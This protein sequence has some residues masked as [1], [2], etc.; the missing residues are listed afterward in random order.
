MADKLNVVINLTA[1]AS[2]VWRSAATGDEAAQKIM[3]LSRKRAF[4]VSRIVQRALR[5]ALPTT[6]VTISEHVQIG[7]PAV[8][9][10]AESKGSSDPVAFE[11]DGDNPL[12]RSVFLSLHIQTLSSVSKPIRVKAMREGKTLH[13]SVQLIGFEAIA[14]GVGGGFIVIKLN[15]G[16]TGKSANY[17]AFLKGHG[18]DSTL[19]KDKWDNALDK[20]KLGKPGKPFFYQTDRAVGF[21]DYVDR[22]V[23]VTQMKAGVGLPL[24]RIPLVNKIPGVDKLGVKV[25]DTVLTFEG[26]GEKAEKLLIKF[27]VKP[28]GLDLGG[29]MLSGTLEPV[30]AL[31]PDDTPDTGTVYVEQPT[32]SSDKQI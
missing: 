27:K 2:S 15:N 9:I 22:K 31:P 12:N 14:R 30:G 3:A 32:S 17:A 16:I 23:H 25:T 13:W 1:R 21:G 5:K 7:E 26:L 29:M 4:V 18:W 24:N 20:M 19:K 6:N 28:G 10:L 8:R 11:L